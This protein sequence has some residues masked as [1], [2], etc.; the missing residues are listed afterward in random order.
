MI[1]ASDE[2]IQKVLD[3]ELVREVA[4]GRLPDDPFTIIFMVDVYNYGDEHAYHGEGPA[5]ILVPRRHEL[6]TFLDTL[7]AEYMEFCQKNNISLEDSAYS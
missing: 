2:A 4:G 1:W 5:M 3:H 6:R 7:Q